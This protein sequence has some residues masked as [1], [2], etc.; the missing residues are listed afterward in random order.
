MDQEVQALDG[1][2]SFSMSTFSTMFEAWRAENDDNALVTFDRGFTLT[3][4]ERPSNDVEND[5][6]CHAMD[7]FLVEDQNTLSNGYELSPLDQRAIYHYRTV[8]SSSHVTKNSFWSTNALLLRLGYEKSMMMHFILAALLNELQ[9]EHS[10]G[11]VEIQNMADFHFTEGSR[12]FTHAM[13]NARRGEMAP[14]HLDVLGSV[15]FMYL[16]L[17]RHRKVQKNALISL[18]NTICNYVSR[19]KLDSQFEQAQY[20]SQTSTDTTKDSAGRKSL[21]A[22]LIH[23]LFFK[24]VQMCFHGCG[25]S[26][27]TY[28][29][30]SQH[31]RREVYQS[32]RGLL[33]NNWGTSYPEDEVI[34]DVENALT[35]ECLFNVF[36]VMQDVNELCNIP[37]K[38]VKARH[39]E[40][41]LD[42]LETVRTK[43]RLSTMIDANSDVDV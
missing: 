27:A 30:T 36:C 1:P 33:A 13:I 11:K 35:L 4:S 26:L 41:R 19:Y 20:P 21:L 24:D 23:W 32:S 38:C 2:A 8:F 18:S 15:F 3:E 37:N 40:Q 31:R 39:I 10:L 29:N 12:L 6:S 14:D 28:I 5:S 43:L 16:Y 22:R 7:I 17:S 25:G 34:D 42:S 9:S